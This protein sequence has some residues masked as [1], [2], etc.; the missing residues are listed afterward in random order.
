MLNELQTWL[1]PYLGVVGENKWL[2]ALLVM[3]CSLLLAWIF[4][5]MTPAIAKTL[6]LS[7]SWLSV[8]GVLYGMLLKPMIDYDTA[9]LPIRNRLLNSNISCS[10]SF[11]C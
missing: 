2:Q 7:T 1:L 9:I 6:F 8:F 5:F 10:L 11:F 3:V 4:G